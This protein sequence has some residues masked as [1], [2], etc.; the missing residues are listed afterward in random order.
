VSVVEIIPPAVRSNLGG[1]HDFGVP[2][3]EY[4]DAVISGL[5]TGRDE[6]AYEFAE[7][8]SQASRAELDMMFRELNR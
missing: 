7:R 5:G 6:V 2:T 1:T 3:G 8:A 4:A